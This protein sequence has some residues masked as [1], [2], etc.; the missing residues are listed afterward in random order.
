MSAEDEVRRAIARVMVTTQQVFVN[1]ATEAKRSVQEGSVVTGAPG[2]PVK[3]GHLRASVLLDFPTPT[4]AEITVGQGL[5]YAKGIEDGV[6]P[7]GPIT[8]RSAVGG[9]HSVR[10]TEIGI[11]RIVAVE[12]AKAAR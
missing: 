12:T 9:F 6:G 3:D 4:R 8:L 11:P 7:H 1:V 5:P 2:Q 10:L